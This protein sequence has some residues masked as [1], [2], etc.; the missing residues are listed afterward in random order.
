MG[1]TLT[2]MWELEGDGAAGEEKAKSE[3][4]RHHMRVTVLVM[5]TRAIEGAPDRVAADAHYHLGNMFARTCADPEA[6]ARCKSEAREQYADAVR[7]DPL[8][9]GARACLDAL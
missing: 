7:H 2:H 6:C 8:H 9:A 1:R 4:S 3:S 5:L